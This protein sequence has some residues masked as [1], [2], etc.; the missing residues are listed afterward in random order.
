LDGGKGAGLWRSRREKGASLFQLSRDEMKMVQRAG[1]NVCF[2]PTETNACV[3]LCGQ[4][5]C[6]IGGRLQWLLLVGLIGRML[7][8]EVGQLNAP[9][10]T[11]AGPG[12]LPHWRSDSQ[13]FNYRASSPYNCV[14]PNHGRNPWVCYP[15]SPIKCDSSWY[16][17]Q[18]KNQVLFRLKTLTS[19][20]LY[21]NKNAANS[22]PRAT[23]TPY[24]F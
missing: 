5:G 6:R 1:A 24:A 10:P 22:S 2:K 11:Q 20:S 21:K 7:P 17:I 16:H 9:P 4:R 8:C 23:G 15:L 13:P 19:P 12:R 18:R 3:R 14:Y